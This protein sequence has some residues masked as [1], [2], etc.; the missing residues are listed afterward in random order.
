MHLSPFTCVRTKR[1]QV[2]V[3]IFEKH[4]IPLVLCG[5]NHLYT[6][7]PFLYTGMKEATSAGDIQKY[8]TYYD[9]TKKATTPYVDERT[10]PNASGGTGINHNEDRAN[11]TLYIQCPSTGWKNSGKETH[12]TQFPT[13]A[14]A[15][16]D[17]NV[18]SYSDGRAWFSAVENT[19]KKPAYLT[20][21]ISST[22]IVGKAYQI[23]GAKS[24]NEY[25]G[26]TYEYAPDME[27]AVLSREL[28]DT[29]TINKSDRA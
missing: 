1:C 2:F 28:I 27:D 6:R 12:I 22:K 19:V 3:P 4:K 25:N 11:G 10:L 8:N 7:T 21:E 13:E 18:G 17:Y 23:T 24:L 20:L 15:G 16:Y 5:H 29:W 26:T 14:V 9:F